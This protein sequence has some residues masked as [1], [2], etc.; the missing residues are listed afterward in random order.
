MQTLLVL[1]LPACTVRACVTILPSSKA[2]HS[3]RCNRISLPPGVWGGKHRRREVEFNRLIGGSG[4]C[5]ASRTRASPDHSSSSAKR[6]LHKADP[7]PGHGATPK[8]ED[9]DFKEEP[10]ALRHNTDPGNTP[11][12]L[13][14]FCDASCQ[15]DISVDMCSVSF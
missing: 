6:G 7:E 10:F 13:G 1:R 14:Q 2:T 12:T 8:V 11:N 3:R 4:A 5:Y 9:S 15:V